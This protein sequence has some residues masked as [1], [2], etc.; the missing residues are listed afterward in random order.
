ML[1]DKIPIQMKKHDPFWKLWNDA[2]T[3]PDPLFDQTEDYHVLKADEAYGIPNKTDE[4]K[5]H[6]KSTPQPLARISICAWLKRHR[7]KV[8]ESCCTCTAHVHV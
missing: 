5:K 1:E 7:A 8:L 4:D 6:R 2:R 3:N